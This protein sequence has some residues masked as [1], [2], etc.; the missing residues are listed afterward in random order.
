MHI[1]WTPPAAA[2]MQ[3]VNDY[4]KERQPEYRQPTLRKLYG[5]I[6]ALKAAPARAC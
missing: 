4:L 1:R 5:K 3:S 2:D 6:R